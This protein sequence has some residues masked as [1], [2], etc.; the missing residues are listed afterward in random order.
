MYKS[1]LI[2]H[3]RKKHTGAVEWRVTA[4][5]IK[6]TVDNIEPEPEWWKHE[7]EFVHV[8]YEPE[9]EHVKHETEPELVK[10]KLKHES[11]DY[12]NQKL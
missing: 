6:M 2:K 7:P 1:E 8:K 3:I 5:K 12:S 11:D 9:P 4:K 10:Y